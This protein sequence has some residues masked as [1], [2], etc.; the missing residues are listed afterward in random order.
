VSVHTVVKADYLVERLP[1][2]LPKKRSRE[3]K[4]KVRQHSL[5][6]EGGCRRINFIIKANFSEKS[7][8]ER[9]VEEK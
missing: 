7:Y 9:K 1:S 2:P 4:I 6:M 5:K 3:R 8:H